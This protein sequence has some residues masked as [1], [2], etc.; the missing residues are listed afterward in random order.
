MLRAMKCM[1]STEENI[2]F[3]VYNQLVIFQES[4]EV[5]KQDNNRDTAV[6]FEHKDDPQS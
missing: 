1:G 5:T 4:W 3:S 2:I 6:S